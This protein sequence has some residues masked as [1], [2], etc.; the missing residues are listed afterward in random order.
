MSPALKAQAES[1]YEHIVFLVDAGRGMLVKA[2]VKNVEVRYP[3]V[4][5]SSN[6]REVEYVALEK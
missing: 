5:N 3:S 2:G 6:S 1:S 4:C